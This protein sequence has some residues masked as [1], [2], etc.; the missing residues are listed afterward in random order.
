MKGVLSLQKM[1]TPQ[2]KKPVTGSCTS[3]ISS[4]CN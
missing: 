4:C 2:L 3:S 1:K